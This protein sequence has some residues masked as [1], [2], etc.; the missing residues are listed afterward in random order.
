[1]DVVLYSK[2]ACS[3]CEKAKDALIRANVAFSETD[4]SGDAGL[5]EE[6][7]M[8]V[9]V[10]EVRGEPVFYAGMDPD[11]LTHFVAEAR[12]R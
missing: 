2:P 12:R 6:F 4:I 8:L 10:V 9:P 7:G 1:M 5:Q 11:D 3:L